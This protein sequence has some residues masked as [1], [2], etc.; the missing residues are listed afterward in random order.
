MTCV[1]CRSGLASAPIVGT[2]DRD[3]VEVRRVECPACHLVQAHPRPSAEEIAAHYA[4]PYWR[5][6]KPP[7]IYLA[8]DG[9]VDAVAPADAER[10]AEALD[11]MA[12]GRVA[13]LEHDL[14]LPPGARVLEVGCGDGRT[15]A[16]MLGLGWDAMGIEPDEGK[17]ETARDRVGPTRTV[18]ASGETAEA[19]REVIE[20]IRHSRIACGTLDDAAAVTVDAVDAVVSFHVLEHVHDPLVALA[21][22]RRLLKPG[23]VLWLEVPD[24]E[25]AR[26]PLD[27]SWW[28]WAHLCDFT[29]ETLTAML[30]CAGLTDVAVRSTFGGLQA[31]GRHDPAVTAQPYEAPPKP[32]EPER[33]VLARFMAGEGVDDIADLFADFVDDDLARLAAFEHQMRLEF[34]RYVEGVHRLGATY[35]TAHR[36]IGEL[37]D[38]MGTDAH[39]RLETWH[40]DPYVHG[41]T[42]GEAYGLQRSSS[43]VQH[44]ANVMRMV[45]MTD[46]ETKR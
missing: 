5:D 41:F 12:R 7:V 3:G 43:M 17:A 30:R 2:R 29:A 32:P 38:A 6:R 28:Q 33:S 18:I 8:S 9:K 35:A 23:G 40:P 42:M 21:S 11:T 22:M 34:K 24:L 31:M 10:Y 26:Q 16:G 44:V 37:G 1:L 36:V 19:T 46:G 45:E 25:N 15:L 14:R 20:A 27:G 13:A 4:G 39:E